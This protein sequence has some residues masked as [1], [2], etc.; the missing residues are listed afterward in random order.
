M[1]FFDVLTA[2]MSSDNVQRPQAEILYNQM[3]STQLLT[4]VFE[5]LTVFST[6]TF[7]LHLRSFSGI[8]LR[9]VLEKTY[10]KYNEHIFT[11]EILGQ[12]RNGLLQIWSSESEVVILRHLSHVLAQAAALAQWDELIPN[13]ISISTTNTSRSP[14]PVLGLI[15]IIA[16]YC[17][18][19]ILSSLD[20]L[21]TFLVPYLS[22]TDSNIQVA[23]S[24]SIGSCMV[25][26]VDDESARMKFKPSLG[27]MITILGTALSNGNESDATAIMENLVTIAANSPVFFRAALDG[28]IP[29]F[30]SVASA[31]SLEFST[32]AMALEF[33]VTIAEEAPALARRCKVLTEGV[34]PLSFSMMLEIEEEEEEFIS[35]KYSQEPGDENCVAGEESIERLS[36]G[37]GGKTVSALILNLVQEYAASSNWTHRRASIAGLHRFC[38]GCPKFAHS[39]LDQITHFL[40][41]AMNDASQRVRFEAIGFVGRLPA[42]FTDDMPQFVEKFVP[43]LTALL[44][45]PGVCDRVRGYSAS[46]MINLINPENISSEIINPFLDPLLSALVVCLQSASVEVQPTCLT[47]LG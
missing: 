27:P 9:R 46:A 26:V 16:E 21:G 45:S 23:C 40:T 25:A 17:P 37:L 5:L 30:I 15:E 33:M 10:Q 2:L 31:D 11:P 1:S 19:D 34:I 4:T 8:L 47:L 36:Y 14:I 38:E 44:S 18:E 7:P 39:F 35:E 6:S 13:I 41:S 29:A 28:V 20:N 43:M 32:R 24:K 3:I 12:I 42:L 22:S